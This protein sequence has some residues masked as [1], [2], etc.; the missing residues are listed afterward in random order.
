MTVVT[1]TRTLLR[2]AAGTFGDA[3][4]SVQDFFTQL[5]AETVDV[6]LAKAEL[7]RSIHR[8]DTTLETITSARNLADSTQQVSLQGRSALDSAERGVAQIRTFLT[9]L[10]DGTHGNVHISPAQVEH[11]FDIVAGR[12]TT[13]R[14]AA[15]IDNYDV[16]VEPALRS[17]A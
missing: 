16:L 12:I 6:D 17:R 4:A 7:S 2:D 11:N 15:P 10:R 1:T 5:R 9:E 14:D 3:R 8:L 13:A